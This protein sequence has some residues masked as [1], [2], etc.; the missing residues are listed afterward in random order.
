MFA[1]RTTQRERSE[2]YPR[3]NRVISIFVKELRKVEE[4]AAAKGE[5]KK[6]SKVVI[7]IDGSEHSQRAFDCKH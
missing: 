5:E 2:D 7:A 6:G 1:F 3:K 4:M